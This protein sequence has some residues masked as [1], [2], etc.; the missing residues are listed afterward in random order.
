MPGTEYVLYV[1]ELFFG[2]VAIVF[3]KQDLS[4]WGQESL[5]NSFV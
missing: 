1:Y 4:L 5:V 3:R 2:G